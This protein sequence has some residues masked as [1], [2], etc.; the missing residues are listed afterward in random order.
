MADIVLYD[1]TG[2]PVTYEGVETITTD[3]PEDGV[4][5]T[6]THGVVPET[7]PEID[8]DFSSGN[9]TY[10]AGDGELLKEV[11][12]KKPE[13][14]LPENITKGTNIAGVE[15]TAV[16]K[17]VSKTIVLDEVDLSEG[18]QT[19]QA[20]TDTLMSEVV[21]EKP[22][23]LLPEN[24]AKGVNIAG[25]VGNA[26]IIDFDSTDE[27]LQ[28]LAYHLN[29]QSTPVLEVRNIEGTK[30][31]N[32]TGSNNIVIPNTLGGLPVAI[33]IGYRN[34]Y[35]ILSS[36][37]ANAIT[38]G[39]NVRYVNNSMYLAFSG[40]SNL[41]SKI[42]I[43]DGI[44]NT[45]KTFQTCTIFNKPVTIPNTVT[46]IANMFRYCNRFMQPLNIPDSVKNAAYTFAYCNNF[47][48]PVS[49]GNG[50]TSME[51]MFYFCNYF[52]QPI[53]IPDSVTNISY[54]FYRCTNFN[55]PV[56]IGNGVVN[57]ENSFEM[58]NKLN[59][60]I[61]IPDS[62]KYINSAFSTCHN[63]AGPIVVGNN[64]TYMRGAFTQ[65]FNLTDIIIY[66]PNV[67][68]A[69]GMLGAKNN[70]VVTNIFVRAGSNTETLMKNNG[71]Y[72]IVSNNIT[73][74]NNAENNCTYNS[75]YNVYIYNNL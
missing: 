66:S 73:W 64:V 75:K 56:I 9:Q 58:C 19:V 3:T 41:N 71:Y 16:G 4:L 69:Y 20:D 26:P 21:I 27:A 54:A 12:L 5:A 36:T 55:Q 46:N 14:L 8:P 38:I 10:K 37:K 40:C 25:V 35:S 31:Y 70:S 13:T 49:I 42:T 68:N 67:I 74:Y 52:N 60:P 47:N 57:M 53:N 65:C 50:V 23:A 6:F 29:T 7:V 72:S 18:S 51:S 33:D 17:G 48:K 28:Y 44:V 1:R 59:Q 32:I 63:I 11:V 2:A 24:V 15:G 30:M 62:V 34:G 22:D 61:N 39:E 45:S 43:P